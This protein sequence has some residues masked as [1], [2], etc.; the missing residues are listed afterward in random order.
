MKQLVT[1]NLLLSL[2]GGACGIGLAVVGT[3]LYPLLVPD[4]FPALLRHVTI[5]ARVLSVRAR[6]LG[7]LERGVRICSRRCGR[8]GWT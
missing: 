7:A 3:R 5:D 4:D 1:E 8:H 2:A 6:D